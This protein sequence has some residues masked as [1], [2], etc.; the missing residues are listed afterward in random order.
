MALLLCCTE[1]NRAPV[2]LSV[3]VTYSSSL[4]LCF[5]RRSP[6][7]PPPSFSLQE[8]TDEVCREGCMFASGRGIKKR[9][10]RRIRSRTDGGF[11]PHLSS[12]LL[13]VFWLTLSVWSLEFSSQFLSS[14]VK[15][16]AHC[17][18]GS[19]IDK[20]QRALYVFFLNI[21]PSLWRV[22]LHMRHQ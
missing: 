9:G 13:V 8:L 6:S 4:F 18:A 21:H 15:E 7:P 14:D 16:M 22:L 10:A 17:K 2:P 1:P 20:R 5:L 19:I 11:S 3:P 12:C